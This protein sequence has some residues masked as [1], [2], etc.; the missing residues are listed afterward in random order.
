MIN[1]LNVFRGHIKWLMKIAEPLR[2]HRTSFDDA[3]CYAVLLALTKCPESRV[4]SPR[5]AA[6]FSLCSL[7]FFFSSYLPTTSIRDRWNSKPA[8]QMRRVEFYS[9]TDVPKYWICQRLVGWKSKLQVG[10]TVSRWISLRKEALS[11]SQRPRAGDETEERVCISDS[12]FQLVLLQIRPPTAAGG[13]SWPRIRTGS[14]GGLRPL[15]PQL[16]CGE[17]VLE[18]SIFALGI[19]AGPCFWDETRLHRS[20]FVH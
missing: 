17:T 12:R 19:K 3:K 10:P 6:V 5:T 13:G 7:A 16:S 15:L 4:I 9:D 20:K 8:L 18:E 11:D 2:V 14:R 1:Y